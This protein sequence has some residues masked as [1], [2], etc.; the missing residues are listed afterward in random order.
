MFPFVA[1]TKN[2]VISVAIDL[3]DMKYVAGY[4]WSLQS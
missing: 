2:S 1:R 4:I 3:S